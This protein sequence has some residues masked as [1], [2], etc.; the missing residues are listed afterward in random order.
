ML[1]DGKSTYPAKT[2]LRIPSRRPLGTCV[3]VKK[4]SA[5]GKITAE[6]AKVVDLILMQTREALSH[7]CPLRDISVDVVDISEMRVIFVG[8]LT[9]TATWRV[10]NEIRT[11]S[12]KA[13]A[14][15]WLIDTFSEYYPEVFFQG[16][17][18]E[19]INE[20]ISVLETKREFLIEPSPLSTS[21]VNP[22][23][24]EIEAPTSITEEVVEALRSRRLPFTD[25]EQVVGESK[26][27]LLIGDPG[28]GKSTA[29]A[30]IALDMFAKCMEAVA[31]KKGFE[32]LEIPILVKA[33]DLIQREVENLI[34]ANMPSGPVREKVKVKVLLVDG[35]DEVEIGSR[36]EIAEK[37][38]G[39]VISTRKVEALKDAIV[40]FKQYELLP[41]EYQQAMDFI[42][43][44]VKDE[45]LLKI[46]N[47]GI[48]RKDL[49]IS[50]TPLALELLIQVVTVE[51]EM[52]ASITEILERYTDGVL[53]RFDTAKGMKSIFEY[54]IK[55]K[56][57]AELSWNEFYLKDRLVISRENFDSFVEEYAQKYGRIR[58]EFDQFLS[59]IVRAGILQIGDTVLFRHRSFL[60][61]F[62]AFRIAQHR[63]DHENLNQDI[64]NIYF[65]LMWTEVAFYYLG[66]LREMS[67]Q[68]VDE[69]DKYDES[70]FESRIQKALIGRLLQAGWDTPS[71]TKLRAMAI[72][73]R[74][75]ENIRN[76]LDS[77]IDRAIKAKGTPI[78]AI[79]SD[80]FIM[81]LAE[82]SFGSMTFLNEV[83]SL[84][85]RISTDDDYGSL[86]ECLLLLWA[87]RRRLSISQT[88]EIIPSVLDVLS[89]LEGLRKLTVRDKYIVLFMIH[90]IQE[91]DIEL[92]KRISKKMANVRRLY[93]SEMSRLLPRPGSGI[94]LKIRGKR[95]RPRS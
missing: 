63:G 34:E 10:E 54:V 13:F 57:L 18:A 28:T 90:H 42:K 75:I 41:F 56:F 22:W 84:C 62:A 7:P 95:R 81:A 53:G 2:Q 36:V 87:N 8:T 25:L 29:L 92:Q 5:S 39:L 23:V 44:F 67:E 50:L 61:F 69:F 48:R 88:S 20:S 76:E 59:E 89:K 15:G 1:R 49:K 35:L 72:A 71:E 9:T 24:S 3:L 64:A 91:E 52:P 12:V 66:I 11:A 65:D 55:K 60:E 70:S 45:G 86:Q 4:G 73:L 38:H 74:Q 14:L 46:I 93:P 31:S 51:K 32:Q 68:I 26:R 83:L 43:R 27:I 85:S 30:K 17:L 19:F 21:F 47:E 82:Y 58:Q 6:S 78:P 79:F 37:G 80:F 77:A 33:R 40:P 16:K 94:T